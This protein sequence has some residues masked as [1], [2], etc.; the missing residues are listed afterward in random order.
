[1]H[2]AIN[3][4]FLK[5]VHAI[6]DHSVDLLIM[7]TPSN[8]MDLIKPPGIQKECVDPTFEKQIER[9]LKP[10]GLWIQFG[11]LTAVKDIIWSLFEFEMHWFHVWQLPVTAP[12]SNEHPVPDVEHI[13]ILKFRDT[14][15]SRLT[16][17]PL[18]ASLGNH[19]DGS[20]MWM[21]K[22]DSVPSKHS[23][24]PTLLRDQGTPTSN[25]QCDENIPPV[26]PISILRTLIRVYSN[27]GDLVVDP[28]GHTGD[29]LVAAKIEGRSCII[30]ESDVR[31]CEIAKNRISAETRQGTLFSS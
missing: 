17:N 10:E 5:E 14:H 7:R 28:F 18:S 30:T 31:L 22:M 3:G 27:P 15:S 24:I 29:S 20:D 26:P 2:K 4:E 9:I 23:W 1:M 21:N 8:V 6:K 11:S 16:F 12:T 19:H 25:L 13:E